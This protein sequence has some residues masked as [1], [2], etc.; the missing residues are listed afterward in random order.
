MS[1]EIIPKIK[2]IGIA[3]T[4]SY[5]DARDIVQET[6]FTIAQKAGQ[7]KGKNGWAWILKI[8]TNYSYKVYNKNKKANVVKNTGHQ[9]LYDG[10]EK[11]IENLLIH[12]IFMKLTRDE[13]ELLIMRF[14][15]DMTYRDMAEYLYRPTSSTKRLFDNVLLKIKKY[16]NLE[17]VQHDT[18][19]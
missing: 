5:E 7:F 1:I 15:S 19:D 3:V 11:A 6:L 17:E 2:A 14:W 4:G 8:A 16:Y 12:E 18:K 9:E 10:E 13:Q